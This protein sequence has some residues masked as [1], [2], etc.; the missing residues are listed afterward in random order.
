MTGFTLPNY[1]D[2]PTSK[3]D[4]LSISRL[5]Y[6]HISPLKRKY[7]FDFLQDIVHMSLDNAKPSNDTGLSLIYTLE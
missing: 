5:I 1:K 2:I 6:R 3:T 7:S 4:I